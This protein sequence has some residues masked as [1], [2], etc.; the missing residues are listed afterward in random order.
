MAGTAT[1]IFPQTVK[2]FP[3]QIQ[4]SDAS[5]KISLVTGAANGSK[6]EALMV[7]STDTSARDL[8]LYMTISSVDYLLT[9]IAI[10]ANSG[11]T[12]AL[13]S[14]DILRNAQI[15]GLAYDSNGNKYLYVANGSVLKINALT[16][17]TSG[18]LIHAL[19]FGGDF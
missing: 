6:V 4:N 1:P 10:P 12:N 11:N 7:S 3:A 16:T 17:V 18:K 13:N 5:N 8:A 9:T 14:I 19:A 2:N 15:P